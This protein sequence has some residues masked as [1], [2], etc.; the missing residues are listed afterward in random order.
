[1]KRLDVTPLTVS[2]FVAIPPEK[3]REAPLPLFHY[4]PV[5]ERMLF[6]SHT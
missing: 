2:C 6:Y 4:R 1:M 3:G 5:A